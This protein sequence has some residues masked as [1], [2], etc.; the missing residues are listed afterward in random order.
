M[1]FLLAPDS[2]KESMTAKE[3]ADAMERGIRKVI[4]YAE[5][6]KVPMADGGEGTV[7]SLVDATEGELYK[8]LVKGPLGDEVE[9]T[10]GVLG[11]KKT[12]VIEMAS[13]SGLHL[14]PRGKRNPLLTTTYGTG[15][16]IKAALDKGVN[17]LIIGIGGSAT[18]DGGAGM[19]QALGGKLLTLDNEEINLGGG[20]LNLLHKID[21]D[22]L[23]KRLKGTKIE[24]ACDVTSPLT[25]KNGASYVFGPQK[26]ATLEMVKILDDN[27]SHY[28]KIIKQQLVIDIESIPG[29]GAA[30]GLGAGLLA[31]FHAELKRGIELVTEHTKLKEKMQYADYVFTG[32]GSIDAQTLYGKTPLGVALIAKEYNIPVIAFAGRIGDGVD[33]LYEHGINSIIGILSE[34]DTI[35]KALKKGPKNI[36]RTCEN[37]ARII[38]LN[39]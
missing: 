4:P 6:I 1:K 20:Y 3:A 16:L 12:A 33:A 19:I 15:Q 2:F 23:D 30:G 18:N 21:L 24:V 22:G 7:Q 28:A 32:E 11:D 31:F 39:K 8:V 17:Q 10:F 37:I 9:A 25:G 14:V 26:G 35:E 29:A 27:L 38:L 13:A 36:E 5:C 34:A